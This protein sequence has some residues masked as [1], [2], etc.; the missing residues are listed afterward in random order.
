MCPFID[1]FVIGEGEDVIHEII[2]AY[3]EWK[4]VKHTTPSP[5]KLCKIWGVYVPHL[6][7]ASYNGDGTFSHID[8]IHADAPLPVVKRIVPKLPPP[9][10]NLSFPISTPFTTDPN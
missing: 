1:A 9:T 3:Q 10:T 2:Q 6:Y 7:Q 4:S 8:K 5:E